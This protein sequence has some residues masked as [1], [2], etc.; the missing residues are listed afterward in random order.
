MLQR[1]P[2]RIHYR[3]AQG[4]RVMDSQ[5]PGENRMLCSLSLSAYE[6]QQ[7]EMIDLGFLER[8]LGSG[9]KGQWYVTVP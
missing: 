2:S 1:I 3:A 7:T 5:H 4:Q 9:N 8:R 6:W